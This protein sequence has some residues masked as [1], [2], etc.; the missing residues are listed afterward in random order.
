MT[1]KLYRKLKERDNPFRKSKSNQSNTLYRENYRKLRNEVNKEILNAKNVYIKNK[2]SNIKNIKE[3]WKETNMI[4]GKVTNKSKDE[5]NIHRISKKTNIQDFLRELLKQYTTNVQS[6]KPDCNINIS[7]Y[8]NRYIRDSIYIPKATNEEVKKIVEHLKTTASGID[9]IRASD[10]KTNN[11][12][13]PV[14]TDLINASI[15]D[16][17]VPQDLKTAI[18]V[19]IHKGGDVMD[20]NNYRPISILPTMSKILEKYMANV[21]TKYLTKIEFLSKAQYAYQSKLG[22][23]QLLENMADKIFRCLDLNINVIV[24]FIDF[25]KAFDLIDTKLLLEKLN[26]LGIRGKNWE[27]FKSYVTDRKILVKHLIINSVKRV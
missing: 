23:K 6:L 7:H 24:T 15:E 8:K 16:G 11:I 19:P 5:Q 20:T 14:I 13:L 9:G 26:N 21:L 1:S 25:S 2:F 22:T 12:V 3:L 17:I 18:I 10:I 4:L 27:W